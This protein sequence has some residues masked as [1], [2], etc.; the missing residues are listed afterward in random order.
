MVHDGEAVT[1]LVGLLHVVGGEQDGLTVGVEVGEDLPHRDPGLRVQ[2]GGGL[3]E[4]QHRGP[5][6][7]GP[8]DHEALGQAT[9]QRVDRHGRPLA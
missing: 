1:E 9:R 6:H 5:V 7:H 2:T 8:G 4:E 3:V